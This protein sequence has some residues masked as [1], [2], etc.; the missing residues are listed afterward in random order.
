MTTTLPPGA[1]LHSL[2]LFQ[3]QRDFVDDVRKYAA[4]VGGVGSGKT[5][6]GVI[7]TLVYATRHPGSLGMVTA[8]TFPMLRDATLRTIL[9]LFPRGQYTFNR[10]DMRISMA[11]G[12]DILLRSTDDPEHLRG[13]NLAY[14][15][16]DEAARSSKEAFLILQGRLRQED[17][18]HQGW[19]TTTPRGLNW[20]YTEFAARDRESY[21]LI[22]CSTRD[23]PFLPLDF[24]ATLEESY[25]A[26]FAL[27]EI[28]GRF[29]V[30][31]G[32]NFFDTEILKELALATEEPTE[33]HLGSTIRIWKRPFTTGRYV[34][35]GDLAWGE[36]GSFSCMSIMDWQTGEVVAELYGRL[37]SDEVAQQATELC[38]TYNYAYV[39]MENNSE[40]RN[41]VEKMVELGY[42]S[43]MYWQDWD[44]KD[45]SR[46]GW[47]TN[48]QTRPVMLAELAEAVRN[49]RLRSYCSDAISEMLSFVR[50]D[51]G[52]PEASEGALADHVMSLAITWQMRKHAVFRSR[53][54][55]TGK[56]TLP[57]SW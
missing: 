49:G 21:N 8:P 32:R 57:V 43:R 7:K 31:G 11:N 54:Q 14:F 5:R 20:L 38:R 10:T 9:E 6:A 56:R 28:E 47:N 24:I 17:M 18:P 15:Y 25:G 29:V 39:G 46:P 48:T 4:F 30:V 45:P 36:K 2:T 55:T 16:M 33:S 19:L 51:S 37:S 22:L 34:A 23:N 3:K 42:G 27:Q 13:P 53:S 12:S 41:I 35:G 1:Q 44:R 52:R 26:E 40:G 50:N